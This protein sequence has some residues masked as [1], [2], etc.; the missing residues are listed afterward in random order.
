MLRVSCKVW[1]RMCEK[2]DT[3]VLL[4]DGFKAGVVYGKTA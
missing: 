1:W 4:F 3:Q 2:F